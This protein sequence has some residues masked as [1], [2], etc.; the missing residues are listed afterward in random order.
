MSKSGQFD[1]LL[2]VFHASVLSLT[3][4]FII[5]L[6]DESNLQ[7]HAAIVL[8]INSYFNMLLQNSQ[9]LTRQMHEKLMSVGYKVHAMK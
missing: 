1:I 6:S 8:Q 3:M 7:I 2:S 4:N 5:A 9:S